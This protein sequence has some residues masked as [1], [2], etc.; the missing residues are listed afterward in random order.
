MQSKAFDKSVSRRPAK[1]L[2]SKTLQYFSIKTNKQ[3]CALCPLGKP[4]R[5]NLENNGCKY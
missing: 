4:Y 3:C 2:L 5:R 1:P